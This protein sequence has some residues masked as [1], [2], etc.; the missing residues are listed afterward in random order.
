MTAFDRRRVGPAVVTLTL[1][2]ALTI[3][4]LPAAAASKPTGQVAFGQATVE[5]AIDDATGANVFLLTPNKV[6][7]PSVSNPTHSCGPDVHTDV[8]SRQQHQSQHAQLQPNNCDHL[9]TFGYPIIGHDHLIGVKPTGD[10]NAA[11]HVFVLAFTP[12][13]FADG[14]VSQ[15][16]LTLAQVEAAKTAGDIVQIDAGFAFN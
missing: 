13:G 12:Q 14:A 1:G 6:P 16:I 11:W 10:F 2:L 9:Q 15:R 4:P 8:S 3:A 5:P 7:F